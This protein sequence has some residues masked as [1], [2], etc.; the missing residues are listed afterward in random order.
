A[1]PRAKYRDRNPRAAF[2]QQTV[3][4]LRAIAGVISAAAVSQLPLYGGGRGGDPF[5]I[6]GR[7]YNPTGRVPQVVNFQIATPDYFRVMQIPLIAG[8]VFNDR[9]QVDVPMVAVINETMARGF[10]NSPTDALGKR[11]LMGAPRPGAQW[12]TIA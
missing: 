11:V 6:E 7:P 2:C 3:D 10:W 1:L 12:L 5:S 9:D 4:G 8:R